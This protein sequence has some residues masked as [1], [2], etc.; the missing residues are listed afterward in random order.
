[1]DFS[2]EGLGDFGEEGDGGFGV[3]VFEAGDDGL[4]GVGFFGQLSLGQFLLDSGSDDLLGDLKFGLEFLVFSAKFGVFH[5]VFV[6]F[7]E[8]VEFFLFHG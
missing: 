4:A 2:V 3:H 6:E 8:G 5:Q 7:L 1:M